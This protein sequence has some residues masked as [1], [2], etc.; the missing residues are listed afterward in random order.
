[1]SFVEDWTKLSDQQ[2]AEEIVALNKEKIMRGERRATHGIKEMISKED[3]QE[4]NTTFAELLE[5][6][7]DRK[8]PAVPCY[9]AREKKK[10]AFAFSAT[11]TVIGKTVQRPHDER[12]ADLDFASE[13]FQAMIHTAIP[14]TR[15]IQSVAHEKQ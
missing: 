13:E 5:V 3:A 4:F 9:T 8:P 6:Y 11:A 7:E 14:M 2:N 10:E 12:H 1:M 15:P